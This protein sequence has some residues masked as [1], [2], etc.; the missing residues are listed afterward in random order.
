[1]LVD[2]TICNVREFCI[3]SFIELSGALPTSEFSHRAP[4]LRA[5]P[6]IPIPLPIR[7]Q[8][9]FVLF[10]VLFFPPSRRRQIVLFCCSASPASRPFS[11][12]KTT[13]SMGSSF[14]FSALF[15]AHGLRK[16]DDLCPNRGFWAKEIEW[17]GW[18]VEWSSSQVCVENGLSHG[19]VSLVNKSSRHVF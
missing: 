8:I 17:I 18:E 7:S 2:C 11:L 19:L 10:L 14:R 5:H 12:S 3:Q 16:H 4:L 6:P 9:E 13:F 15:S 1:M